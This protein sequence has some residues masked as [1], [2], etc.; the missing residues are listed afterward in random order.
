MLNQELRSRGDP[1]IPRFHRLGRRSRMRDR[2]S[3]LAALLVVVLVMSPMSVAAAGPG[4]PV[5]PGDPGGHQGDSPLGPIGNAIDGINTAD[6]GLTEMAKLIAIEFGVSVD[7]ALARL[8]HQ[9]AVAPLIAQWRQQHP[10]AFGGAYHADGFATRTTV[11]WVGNAPADVVADIEQSGLAIGVDATATASQAALVAKTHAI[12]QALHDAG[13]TDF[14]VAPNIL[15]QGIDVTLS[16][17]DET[18]SDADAVERTIRELET[19]TIQ[20]GITRVTE[21]PFTP[22]RAKGG[23]AAS[24]NRSG[25]GVACTFSFGVRSG[26]T[27]G[28]L[29]AGHCADTLY[30]VDPATGSTTLLTLREEYEGYYGDFA[31]YSYPGTVD[32]KF[33]VGSSTSSLRT[34]T[35]VKSATSIA[36]GDYYCKYGRASNR[37]DCNNVKYTDVCYGDGSGYLVCSQVRMRSVYGAKGDSGGPWFSGT[38]AVGI[39]TG[40]YGNI[41][42]TGTTRSEHAFTPVALAASELRVQILA[43]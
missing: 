7:T 5:I 15:T 32:P 36:I 11:R 14:V 42:S 9:K 34:V 38:Q 24:K 40:R 31:W 1:R 12:A 4:D 37:R 33:Y 2:F 23:T 28:L 16:V 20:A 27:Y 21:D 41:G 39:N 18:A 25:S 13:T 26:S 19:P 3:V 22:D 43:R 17:T 35:S 10:D 8:R 30:Y 29:T 6:A